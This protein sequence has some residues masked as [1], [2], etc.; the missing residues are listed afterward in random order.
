MAFRILGKIVG[1][2]ICGVRN[3][4]FCEIVK[5]FSCQVWSSAGQV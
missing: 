4:I 5:D 1:S 3:T 2:P